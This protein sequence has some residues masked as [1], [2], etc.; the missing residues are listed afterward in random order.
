MRW[1]KENKISDRMRRLKALLDFEVKES[2]KM[3]WSQLHSPAPASEHRSLV[4]IGANAATYTSTT[5]HQNHNHLRKRHHHNF[6][7]FSS[8]STSTAATPAEY[9]P[10]GL[11]T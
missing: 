2:Q 6:R 11:T 9:S 5:D 10:R 3:F 1:D 4:F 7:N 8:P